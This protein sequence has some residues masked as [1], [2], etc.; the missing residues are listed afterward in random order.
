VEASAL[1][2]GNK[3]LQAQVKELDPERE[4]LRRAAKYFAGATSW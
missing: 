3:R 4:N 2:R 1:E